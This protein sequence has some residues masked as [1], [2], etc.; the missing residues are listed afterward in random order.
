[1]DGGNHYV[2]LAEIDVR[3]EDVVSPVHL[4]SR[5]RSNTLTSI[6][7]SHVVPRKHACTRA[8]A[9]S[10]VR[11]RGMSGWMCSRS[12]WL[13]FGCDRC[14]DTADV[15]VDIDCQGGA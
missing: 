2:P 9:R 15:L 8:S 10:N 5:N 11:H 14:F 3:L 7:V 13:V 1:M 12:G 6:G 4:A